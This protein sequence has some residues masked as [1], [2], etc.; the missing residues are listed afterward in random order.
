M[1]GIVIVW[2]GQFERR[3]S[4]P[5]LSCLIDLRLAIAVGHLAAVANFNWFRGLFF[6]KVSL[7]VEHANEL[8]LHIL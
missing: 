2:Y 1:L 6:C 4:D 7:V 8:H 3:H 5:P